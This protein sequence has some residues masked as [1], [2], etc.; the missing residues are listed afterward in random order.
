MKIK[1]TLTEDMLGTVP[2]DKAI[3]TTYIGGLKPPGTPSLE[4]EL[5]DVVEAEEKG[6]TGFHRDGNG[7]FVL[8]YYIKGFLKHSAN[9][10]KETLGI[11]ALRSKITD[12]V[13][14][15]PRKVYLGKKEP[16][17]VFERP[18]QGMTPQG[19][20][21]SLARSDY[22]AAG[23]KFAFELRFFPPHKEITR[24]VIESILEYGAYMGFGQF[25]NGSF[26]RFTFEIED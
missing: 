8:D 12:F 3:Y 9:V 16:D 15:F 11:K 19:P 26:G 10:Q 4:N 24:K 13:F 20:K 23:T 2:K 7:L 18:R 21:T 6:W 14:V 5:E 1:I 17:G 25:R 22:V